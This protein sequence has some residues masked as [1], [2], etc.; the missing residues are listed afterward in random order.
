MQQRIHKYLDIEMVP[1]GTIGWYWHNNERLYWMIDPPD[2]LLDWLVSIETKFLI[3][4]TDARWTKSWV[5]WV[6][7]SPQDEFWL[8]I[9]WPQMH[10]L[11]PWCD[12]PWWDQW[13]EHTGDDDDEEDQFDL[14]RIGQYRF[15]KNSVSPNWCGPKKTKRVR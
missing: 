12:Y 1:E 2:E 3:S 9:R 13:W 10:S 6:V 8:K 11:M 5:V 15:K 7:H 4:S 14:S